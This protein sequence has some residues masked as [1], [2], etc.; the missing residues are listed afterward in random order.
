MNNKIHKTI[1]WITALILLFSAFFTQ[2]GIVTAEVGNPTISPPTVIVDGV[3]EGG[4]IDSTE[5]ITITITLP[6]I[7]IE[8]DGGADYFEWGDEFVIVLSENFMFD[9]IPSDQDLMFGTIRVGTVKFSNVDGHA[10]A[11]IVLDGEEY[12]F[13]PDVRPE[14]PPFANLSAEFECSLVYNQTYNLDDN[15]DKYVTILDKDYMI[16]LPG[17]VHTYSVTK[18][19][20]SVNLADG[21][22]TWS[23][24]ITGESDTKPPTPLDLGGFLFEDDL[25]S[26]G[27]FVTGSFKVGG[28]S[29]VP[30]YTDQILSYTL[31]DNSFSQVV[32]T[33]TTKI[34]DDV[35]AGGGTVTNTAE[36]T[37][38]ELPIGS[39]DA[40]TTI[41]GPTIAKTGEADDGFDNGEYDP[42]DRTITWFI[43]VD[44]QGLTL[45]DLTITD[46]L[47]DGLTF[48]SAVWQRWDSA[49]SSWVDVVGI[50]WATEPTD[51][52]YEIGDVNYLGRLKIITNVPD[53]DEGSVN[54]RK[55]G[56]QASA[57]W[58]SAGGAPGTGE[59]VAEGV[60]I[61]YD[62][63]T[64]TGTQS[65]TDKANHQISW[66]I[67]VNLMGQS[68]TDFVYYDLFVHDAATTNGALTGATGW[69]VGLVIG[70]PGVTRNNGQKFVGVTSQDSHLTV[71]AIPLGTLGTLVK[72]ST[73]QA[74]GSNQVV[75]KSQVIDPSILAGNKSN[76]TVPNVASLYKGETYRG[77]DNDSVPFNNLV[78]AKE[79]LNRVEV[80]NDHDPL[81]DIDPNNSTT[82]AAD[83]F[84]YDYKEVIFRLNINGA[85]LDFEKVETNLSDGFGDV[86][87]TDTLPAG[88]EFSAFSG[89]AMFLI[90]DANGSAVATIPALDPATISGFTPTVGTSTATFTFTSLD[91]PYV[92][93]VKAKPTN[94]TFDGYLVGANT[95]LETNSLNL[96][97]ANWEPGVTVTQ[98]VRVNTELIDKSIELSQQYSGILTWVLDYTP[99]NRP[100]AEKIQDVLPEGIDLRT[101]SSG[102]L[103]WVQDGVRNINVFEL[104]LNADGSYTQ[105][106]ELDLAVIQANLV[107]DSETRTL[108]FTFP[109]NTKAYR[110]S[111]LTDI[112]G[113]PG[114]ITNSVSLIGAEGNG[115]ETS[116]DFIITDQHGQAQVGRSGV[117]AIT[118]TDGA[119][120][121]LPG[122][123]FTLY[124]TDA[125]NRTT[126][127]TVRVTDD[128]G[129]IRIYGLQ[130]GTYILVETDPPD[131]YYGPPIEFII[132]VDSTY[133][134]TINGTT[135][136]NQFPY[137]VVNHLIPLQAG[138]LTISKTVAGN[139]G[140]DDK[141][142][143]FT[144][145]F[146][147]AP[148]VYPYTGNGVPNGYISSGN[149]FY[150]AHNQSI[151][152]TGLPVD[153]EYTIVE[154][155]YEPDGYIVTHTGANGTIAL[156]DTQIAEFTNTREIG[157]L[158]ISKTVVGN[159]GDPNKVFDFT[160]TFTNAPY[161]YPY[162]GSG[163]AADGTITSGQ[164]IQLK[165][166]QSITINDL[167]KGATYSVVEADYSAEGYTTTYSGAAGDIVVGQT[168]TAAFTNTREIG[169]LTIKKTVAGDLADR[170]RYFTFVVEF[171][172]N[173]VYYY[174]GSKVGAIQ[175]GQSVQLKHNEYIVIE[176]ILIG[177]TYKVTEVEENWG[178]YSTSYTGTVGLMETT[179]KTA[180][181]V[182]WRSSVPNTG[183]DDTAATV[184]V[185]LII[186]VSLLLISTGLYGYIQIKKRKQTLS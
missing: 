147:G 182:N 148:D 6:S 10:V 79:M 137:E 86:T 133:A 89:G 103:I 127:R 55:Y 38:D 71:E 62:A 118:K 53:E 14:E 75:M 30:D 128:S 11:T 120:R 35:L 113:L 173:E 141:Q 64:K 172:S 46:V 47:Q 165:H 91:Q 110:I 179:G 69:P 129:R 96:Q 131:F 48:E 97:T 159:G 125:G 93:L 144:I 169:N 5:G 151:T 92:I 126:S 37:D 176:E 106:T 139:G 143:A 80:A 109:D 61:G 78:L 152:I 33:F 43:P 170:N 104:I 130:P 49:T 24:T 45:H 8:G 15:E 3:D 132:V 87:V 13:D 83:G 74:T 122:A 23:V 73:L 134:T 149:T 72:V 77:R 108:T 34:P 19:V 85:G 105:S 52:V 181:F 29:E 146:V 39:D 116:E 16:Q 140:E 98:D 150:L 186:S 26:V 94:E 156:N 154:A 121:L 50:S 101:D 2:T 42:T 184:R 161:I 12:I 82:T 124:N 84:H 90:Y 185:G 135:M 51:G 56:N 68:A 183:D 171:G 153:A 155:N 63:I 95:R 59:A 18:A 36:V 41:T 31:P 177:T 17:D 44:N 57:A 102:A 81:L 58:E 99:F 119:G 70:N 21:T 22:I 32:I 20:D 166:G 28:N 157:S 136:S 163:G 54:Y 180:A 142:F 175:S 138:G 117:I 40:S 167:P 107:Y 9:P 60:G 1:T 65:D 67:N 27:A 25:T 88:W 115:T 145:T 123:E 4:V 7:P 178:G 114:K 112:T 168:Q 66:T 160:V 100:I 158:T 164:T 111:Y 76:Q 174:H 162:V